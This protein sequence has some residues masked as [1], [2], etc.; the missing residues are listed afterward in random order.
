M[1][2]LISKQL[3]PFQALY[4]FPIQYF[5][6]NN[7]QKLKDYLDFFVIEYEVDGRIIQG[8]ILEPKDKSKKYPV[9]I[10]GRGGNN[11]DPLENDMGVNIFTLVKGN[12][13]N[14]CINNY[15][16]YVSQ[17]S[18]YGL[19]SGKD[20]F[21]GEDLNDILALKNL[22]D[23]NHI[24]DSS[25]VGM[26]GYSR[27]G[28]MSYLALT[29]TD[30]LRTIAVVGGPTNLLRNAEERTNMQ[31]FVF[32]PTFGGSEDEKRRRSIIFNTDKLPKDS[33][34]LMLHGKLDDRV[35]YKDA[36]ELY[37]KLS[38]AKINSKL[39]LFEDDTH[40]ILEH[41]QERDKEIMEWF[42]KYL[43]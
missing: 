39:V 43:K 16:I 2:K 26:L 21:G 8:A 4:W 15:V 20:E 37:E 14:Y 35:N 23:E 24:C 40:N 42:D 11:V 19:N 29:K 36:T 32:T 31:E 1:T 27:G 17:L 18:G 6:K 12:V 9:I 33:N 13:F 30:W 28:I 34:I 3:L 5:S 22:I 41:K 25:R 38:A 10:Y 7:L